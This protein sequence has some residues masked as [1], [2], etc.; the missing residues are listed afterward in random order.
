MVEGGGNGK[1]KS[2]DVVI[3]ADLRAYRRGHAHPGEPCHIVGGGPIPVRVAREL[4]RDAFLKAVLHDGVAVQTV[5][6]FGRHRP[7]HL[8]TALALGA[9]PDFDGVTCTQLGCDRKHG[10]QWDHLDPYANGGPTSMANL[11][12]KCVP[13]HCDKTESDRRAGLLGGGPGSRGL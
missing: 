6:H 1:A 13:H 12:P 10:L 9:P 7:A 2:A 11:K 3:V 4:A 5:A 8:E